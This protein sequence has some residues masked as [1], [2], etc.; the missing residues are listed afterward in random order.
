MGS[1]LAS[2]LVRVDATVDE[3]AAML[4]QAG[5]PK[6]AERLLLA[7]VKRDRKNARRLAGQGAPLAAPAATGSQ[8]V[9]ADNPSLVFKD[10]TIEGPSQRGF[11]VTLYA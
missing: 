7:Q 4:V 2:G 3:V 6:D 1:V 9:V 11:L 8:S 5:Y 10:C